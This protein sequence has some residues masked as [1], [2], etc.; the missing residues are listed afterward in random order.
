MRGRFAHLMT[1]VKILEAGLEHPNQSIP[2]FKNL[3]NENLNIF[4]RPLDD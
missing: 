3:F 2:M 1:E 4:T